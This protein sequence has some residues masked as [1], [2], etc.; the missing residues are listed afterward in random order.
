M[1]LTQNLLREL[2]EYRDG[3]LYWKISSGNMTHAGDKVSPKNHQKYCQVGINGKRY[4]IHRII[5]LYH[6]G[7][8]PKYLDHID[9][10]PLNN[11]IENLRE[12][13]QS[14]NCMNSKSFKNSS[15]KFKGVSWDKNRNKW[16][17][18]IFIN[19]KQKHLGQFTN[20]SDAAKAYNKAAIKAFGE[21]AHI[22]E[23]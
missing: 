13:T 22:N 12:V 8:L 3:N 21:F 23:L 7:Y 14:Q 19:G 4:Y 18:Y 17:S 2:F 15:S 1:E 6:H 11:K 20:E 10:D 9:R 5:Y 16:R